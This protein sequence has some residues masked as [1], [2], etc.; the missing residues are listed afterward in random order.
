ML[1][2]SVASAAHFCCRRVGGSPEPGASRNTVPLPSTFITTA[3]LPFSGIGPRFLLPWTY[4]LRSSAHDDLGCA[5]KQSLQSRIDRL[6]TFATHAPV[7]GDEVTVSI[8]CV[9][10]WGLVAILRN[11]AHG[12]QR[13]ASGH[14]QLLNSGCHWLRPRWLRPLWRTEARAVRCWTS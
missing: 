5:G 11:V 4:T 3:S 13:A 6:L 12:R 1:L 10:R 7:T 14:V 2:I 8:D 9:G